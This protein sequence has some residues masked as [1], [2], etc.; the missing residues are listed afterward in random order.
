LIGDLDHGACYWWQVQAGEKDRQ[1]IVWRALFG[2][3]LCVTFF[4]WSNS[5]CFSSIAIFGAVFLELLASFFGCLRIM[6]DWFVSGINVQTGEEVAV[7]L[8]FLGPSLVLVLF[9]NLGKF[10]CFL[11]C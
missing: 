10:D 9:E 6:L 7:K 5:F 1:W 4:I 11:G 3:A 8:V 2:Y